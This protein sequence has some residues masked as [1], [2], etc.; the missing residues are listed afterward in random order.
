MRQILHHNVFDDTSDQE[1]QIIC[2]IYK[3]KQII[4]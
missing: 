3:S 4:I 2:T 1:T